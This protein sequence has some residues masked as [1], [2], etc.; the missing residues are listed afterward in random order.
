M[1]RVSLLPRSSFGWYDF[2]NCDF[3]GGRRM[4]PAFHFVKL[5]FVLGLL[6][7]FLGVFG[8]AATRSASAKTGSGHFQITNLTGKSVCLAATVRHAL[9]VSDDG[10][11]SFGDCR[12][13]SVR[14]ANSASSLTVRPHSDARRSSSSRTSFGSTHGW[15]SR[16]CQLDASDV[17]SRVT[18]SPELIA[19]DSAGYRRL[20][21]RQILFVG[22]RRWVLR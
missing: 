3:G 16:L 9:P 19:T 7:V 10:P 5:R 22:R 18:T 17:W 14:V 2:G 12:E 1:G 21:R 13:G 20:R 8:F 15:V 4:N 6:S 11:H